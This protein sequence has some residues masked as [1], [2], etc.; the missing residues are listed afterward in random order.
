MGVIRLSGFMGAAMA[1][2]PK[3]LPESVGVTSLNQKLG[4]GDLR[5]CKAPLN[6]ATVG[7]GRKS[8]YRMGRDVPS[9]T[10]YWLSWTTPV[11]VVRGYNTADTGERT[12]YSGDDFPKWTDTTKALGG[13][14]PTAW[15]ALGIP[16]PAA[17]PTLA[18]SGGTSTD[19]ETRAY[20]YTYVT[21][22]GEESAPSAATLITLKPDDT[23]TLTGLSAA[24]AGSYGITLIRIYRTESTSSGSDFFF[25]R[26]IS[27]ALTT[28]TDDNR[29]LQEVLATTTW[30]PAPGVPQGGA[31][32]LTES[33]LKSLTGLWNG[34]M[35]GIAGRGIRFS[36]PFSPY[37]W[38]LQ[39]ELVPSDVTPVAC[40]AFGQ[41]LVVVTNGK[42]VVV[43]GVSPESMDEQPVD[44]L[45]ACVSELSV[46]SMGSGVAWASPD[47]LAYIGSDGSRIL[48]ASML[49]KEDWQTLKPETIIGAFFEGRYYGFYEPSP[50]VKKSFMLDPGNTA[51]LYF[52]DIGA[53]AVYVDDLQDAMY[54]LNGTS[55]QKWDAGA[56][57]TVTFKSK[58]FE[59]PSATR[60]FARAKVVA[61]VYPVTLKVYADGNLVLTHTVA[62]GNVF[63]LPGGYWANNFQVELVATGAV[64]GFAMAHSVEELGGA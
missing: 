47:G 58:V 62:D 33:A 60:A 3:L 10:N 22:A 29:D 43:T 11:N 2:H 50:G 23:V 9:D 44:F 46:V 48:T 18:A 26:E 56:G 52:S 39:Y 49:T 32:N 25:L 5:P 61:D 28:T 27:S 35:G 53:D 6:V 14:P 36:E 20:C 19:S 38:P 7:G 55:V 37:A 24:P 16:A 45:Q 59:M 4:R 12:C 8:I 15:R 13:S 54:V 57:K 34:M 51:G 30:V 17:A 1:K 41:T 64:Q 31:S 42:P 21:D 63:S 40:A